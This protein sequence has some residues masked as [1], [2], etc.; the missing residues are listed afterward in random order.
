MAFGFGRYPC[1]FSWTIRRLPASNSNAAKLSLDYLELP[2]LKLICPRKGSDLFAELLA[3]VQLTC[4]PFFRT[5]AVPRMPNYL[6][7]LFQP[8]YALLPVTG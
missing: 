5:F 3:A 6:G 2:P 8:A 4:N 1:T 7:I